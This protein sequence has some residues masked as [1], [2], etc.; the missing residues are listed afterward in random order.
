MLYTNEFILFRRFQNQKTKRIRICQYRKIII[1]NGN[2]F[3]IKEV[4]KSID[5]GIICQLNFPFNVEKSTM[6]NEKLKLKKKGCLF[7]RI[8]NKCRIV[9]H[10]IHLVLGQ[11]SSFFANSSVYQTIESTLQVVIEPPRDKAIELTLN[12]SLIT[13]STL[14]EGKQN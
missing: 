7:D 10:V 2:V 14:S 6:E 11:Q 9:L 4:T 12:R 8:V 13:K 5:F 1:W 3:H